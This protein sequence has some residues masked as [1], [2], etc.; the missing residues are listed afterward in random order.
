M[1]GGAAAGAGVR[2][3]G[4]VQSGGGGAGGVRGG[5]P[6]HREDGV[7]AD[8]RARH[9]HHDGVQ[10]NPGPQQSLNQ[11]HKIRTKRVCK[12]CRKLVGRI[13]CNNKKPG[14][15]KLY[16]KQTTLIFLFRGRG[17]RVIIYDACLSESL[18]NIWVD[19]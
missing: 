5:V 19:Q 14:M 16:S 13:L 18:M 9:P 4:G 7:Q 1:S 6:G 17:E 15:R 12:L 3:A 2:A 8:G 11:D 10:R